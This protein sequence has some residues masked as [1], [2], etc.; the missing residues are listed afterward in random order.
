MQLATRPSLQVSRQL[1][2][3]ILR[4]YYSS[5]LEDLNAVTSL[6]EGAGQT[7]VPKK[8]SRPHSLGHFAQPEGPFPMSVSETFSSWVAGLSR[9]EVI[10]R[11]QVDDVKNAWRKVLDAKQG[12]DQVAVS[13]VIR[14]LMARGMWQDVMRVLRHWVIRDNKAGADAPLALERCIADLHETGLP[15]DRQSVIEQDAPQWLVPSAN[16]DITP[17]TEWERFPRG[18]LASAMSRKEPA[19]CYPLWKY[20]PAI[21]GQSHDAV[22]LSLLIIAAC[23]LTRLQEGPGNVNEAGQSRSPLAFLW[24]GMPALLRVIQIFKDLLFAAHPELR[25]EHSAVK[26]FKQAVEWNTRDYTQW[27]P[28]SRGGTPNLSSSDQR[29]DSVGHG[30]ASH[31]RAWTC[32]AFGQDVFDQYLRALALAQLVYNR[33]VASRGQRRKHQRQPFG[34]DSDDE[35]W[36]EPFEVLSWMRKLN[37]QPKKSSLAI[38]SVAARQCGTDLDRGASLFSAETPMGPLQEYCEEWIDIEAFPQMQDINRAWTKG[39]SFARGSWLPPSRRS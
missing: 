26:A 8:Y 14:L 15:V 18:L 10:H 3:Q 17:H 22:S 33:R 29:P 9:K 5:T 16:M 31:G 38:I 2:R 21:C 34:V 20:G 1:W 24:D 13:S 32:I 7:Q 12:P 19:A 37:V 27:D 23:R 39:F 35:V 4:H 36:L 28:N 11:F 6:F 25:T 30:L